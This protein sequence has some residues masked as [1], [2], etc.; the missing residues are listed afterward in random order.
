MSTAM[1]VVDSKA[2]VP[3]TA[4]DTAFAKH[5]LARMPMCG[6]WSE[7]VVA[8]EALPLPPINSRGSRDSEGWTAVY[9]ITVQPGK[10]TAVPSVY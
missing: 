9:E 2:M 8:V 10:N 3:A 6:H 7:S 1:A 5:V 4:E